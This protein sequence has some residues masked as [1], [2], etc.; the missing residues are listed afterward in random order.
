MNVN[1]ALDYLRLHMQNNNV[2]KRV[3]SLLDTPV[4]VNAVNEVKMPTQMND[5][6]FN[7]QQQIFARLNHP[8]N[9]AALRAT[10]R[11]LRRNVPME[12]PD[13]IDPFALVE[14]ATPAKTPH[15]DLL[16][17]LHSLP[18][19]RRLVVYYHDARIQTEV[20]WGST[21]EILYCTCFG[22][23]MQT[24]HEFIQTSH[25]RKAFDFINSQGRILR[26]SIYRKF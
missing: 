25:V 26:F 11:A 3:Q 2:R 22:P 12:R 1:S 17:A 7:V 24:A 5:L 15:Y 4:S 13:V 20:E 14:N 9:R 23:S 10:S 18:T 21:K 16:M 19:D 6:P 8:F